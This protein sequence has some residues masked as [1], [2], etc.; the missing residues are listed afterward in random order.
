MSEISGSM[1]QLV[2]KVNEE[3][4]M[5]ENTQ[6]LDELMPTIGMRDVMLLIKFEIPQVNREHF[7]IHKYT[8]VPKN[9]KDDIFS[10]IIPEH[11]LMAMSD[12]RRT[13]CRHF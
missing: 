11:E 1:Q 8:P 4:G 12:S 5:M 6:N 3:F 7:I 2:L 13:T 10:I 9:I